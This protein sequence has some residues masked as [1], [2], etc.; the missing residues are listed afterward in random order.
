MAAS[1]KPMLKP[2]HVT[3]PGQRYALVSFVGPDNA[4]RQKN[5]QLGMKIRGC[6]ATM[7]EARD[8]AKELMEQ[9]SLVDIFVVEM[10][11][12]ALIPPDQASMQSVEYKDKLLDELMKGHVR[13]QKQARAL[14]EQRKQAIL[15]EGLDAHLLPDERVVPQVDDG[16]S[17]ETD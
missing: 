1:A 16:P 3:V 2:D 7:D 15:A 4:L 8:H 10:Y 5:E 13:N 11:Q 6:F 14:F 9:D 12:W 17:Y